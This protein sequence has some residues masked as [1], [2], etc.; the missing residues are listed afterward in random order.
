MSGP[1]STLGKAM[2]SDSE[3]WFPVL[4][5]GRHAAV[6]HFALG[7]GGEV[8]EVL[9]LIKKVNR[10][11]F[12]YPEIKEA[13]SLELADVIT[14]LLDLATVLEI[15]MDVAVAEK[16]SICA[17]R[18]DTK[19]WENTGTPAGPVDGAPPAEEAPEEEPF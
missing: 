4:H 8:G 14:Y 17:A 16:R 3:R 10:H 18:W 13:L 19:P 1:L 7:L 2:L 15:D 5:G 12:S 11:D 6:T 9:N